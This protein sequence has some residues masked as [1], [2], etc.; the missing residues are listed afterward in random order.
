MRRLRYS[1]ISTERS[2]SLGRK[3]SAVQGQPWA[4]QYETGLKTDAIIK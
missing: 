1:T 3:Q 4:R 2:G